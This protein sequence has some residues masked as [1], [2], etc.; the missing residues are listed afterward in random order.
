MASSSTERVIRAD[1]SPRDYMANALL[2]LAGYAL[3]IDKVKRFRPLG[4][5]S[6]GVETTTG[7]LGQGLI[8]ALFFAL[9]ENLQTDEFKQPGRETVNH[10][11]FALLGDGC[12]LQSISCE[13]RKDVLGRSPPLIGLEAGVTRWWSQ[14]GC[15]AALGVD[16]FGE[17]AP[18]AQVFEHFG[19]SAEALAE[20]VQGEVEQARRGLRT[21]H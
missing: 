9:A 20:R 16:S 21:S 17:S 7:L 11:A 4:N 14:Y 2:H 12:L 10:H 5:K 18:A 1:N 8:N 3:P 19:L 15:S 6:R 13:Y